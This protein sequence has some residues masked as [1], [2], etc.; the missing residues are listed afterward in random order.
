MLLSRGFRLRRG[1]RQGSPVTGHAGTRRPAPSR[2][3]L[4]DCASCAAAPAPAAPVRPAPRVR[5]AHRSHQPLAGEG[6]GWPDDSAAFTASVT[7]SQDRAGRSRRTIVTT[8]R[9]RAARRPAWSACAQRR[10]CSARPDRRC[11]GGLPL[12]CPAR[13]LPRPGLGALDD[14]RPLELRNRA[15]D[16]Q[17]Q[18]PRWPGGVDRIA[19]RAEMPPVSRTR[20]I[21]ASRCD[22]ERAGRSIRTTTRVSPARSQLSRRASSGRARLVPEA[23]SSKSPCSLWRAIGAAAARG[24]GP[25]SRLWRRPGPPRASPSLVRP[26]MQISNSPQTVV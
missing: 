25:G 5:T 6:R 16:L 17:H 20:S 10:S 1:S 22:N 11:A 13:G 3:V 2:A 12:P 26:V 23:F 24:P 8:H 4:S 19:E 18:H 7:S 15:H 14:Q 9:R 21:T